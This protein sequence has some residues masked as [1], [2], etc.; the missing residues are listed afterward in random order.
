ML[1]TFLALAAT[2]ASLLLASPVTQASEATDAT[3]QR[4]C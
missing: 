1:R 4:W 3:E 2:A